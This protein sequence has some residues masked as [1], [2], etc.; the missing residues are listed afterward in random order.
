MELDK[1]ILDEWYKAVQVANDHLSNKLINAFKDIHPLEY[2]YISKFFRLRT[3]L[4]KDIECLSS[5]GQVQWFTLTFDNDYDV[6]KEETKRKSAFKFLNEIF[7]CFLLVEEYG[8]DNGRYHI[9]GFG[10]YRIGKD[11]DNFREWK[12]IQNIKSLDSVSLKKKAKYLTKYAVKALPR[13][14]RSKTYIMYKKAF[15]RLKSLKKDFLSCYECGLNLLRLRFN[16]V[17][18]LNAL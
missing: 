4:Y 5:L 2:G 9:H 7:L 17:E 15:T 11:F 8:E 16:R 13:L 1:I 10:V 3:E 18:L 14:R 6:M 12:Y